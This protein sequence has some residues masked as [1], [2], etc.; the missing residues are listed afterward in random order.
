MIALDPNQTVEFCLPADEAV[1]PA[2]RAVFVTRYLTARQWLAYD[3]LL[4]EAIGSEVLDER[5]AKLTAAIELGLVGWRNVPLPFAA[6]AIPDALTLDEI[7][8]LAAA[9]WRAIQL[10]ESDRKKSPSRSQSNAA[11]SAPVA[12][13]ESA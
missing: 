3:R 2:T 6:G 4:S 12:T 11:L 7:H 5:V 9:L 1:D 10:A 13:P 8:E